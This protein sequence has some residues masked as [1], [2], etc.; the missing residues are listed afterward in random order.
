[1]PVSYRLINP[2]E[3]LALLSLW[4]DVFNVP[5]DQEQQRF[6]SDPDRYQTTFVAIASDGAIL[7]SAHYRVYERRDADGTPRRVGELDPVATRSD[8]QRHGHATQLTTHALNAMQRD[9]CDWSILETSE[10]GRP[11][12]QRFGWQAFPM[13]YRRGAL[14]E[15]RPRCPT[16]YHTRR[17]DPP[18]AAQDWAQFARLYSAYN[19]TRPLTVVRDATYWQKFTAVRLMQ[20]IMNEQLQVIGAWSTD[21]PTQ[22]CGYILVHFFDFAFLVKEMGALPGETLAITALVAAVSDEASR[23]GLVYG[24]VELPHEAPLD[25]IIADLFGTSLHLS[26]ANTRIMARPINP[27][28]HMEQLEAIFQAPNAFYSGIDHF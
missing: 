3:E 20:R 19:L 25:A 10:A 5:Y 27:G 28:F 14:S 18:I 26:D 6:T 12:Y 11:L 9:G 13:R 17:Y 15:Q 7:S 4:S 2:A 23:R 22:L 16:S 8:A 1:M 21:T 24:E